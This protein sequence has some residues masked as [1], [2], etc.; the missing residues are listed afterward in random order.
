MLAC[1]RDIYVMIQLMTFATHSVITEEECSLGY[2]LLRCLRL[3][4][5][6]DM[7]TAL[8]VHTEDTIAQGCEAVQAF[9]KLIKVSQSYFIY[10]CQI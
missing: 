2:L 4:L 5:V 7:Y 10:R 9:G 8:E 6:L 1:N 3:F